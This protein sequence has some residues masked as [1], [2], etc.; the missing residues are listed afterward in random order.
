MTISEN[1][2]DAM[3]R[4]MSKTIADIRNVL[5]RCDPAAGAALGVGLKP[6]VFMAVAQILPLSGLDKV[7][8]VDQRMGQGGSLTARFEKIDGIIRKLREEN[9]G[10]FVEGVFERMLVLLRDLMTELEDAEKA[11]AELRR[12]HVSAAP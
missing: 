8:E 9:T 5:N 7:R 6:V 4:P 10:I 1:E 11:L 12:T 3:V 2:F